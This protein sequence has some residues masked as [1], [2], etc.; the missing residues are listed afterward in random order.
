MSSERLH[1]VDNLNRC[2]DAKPSTRLNS[3]SCGEELE[4]GLRDL[5]G[6]DTPHTNKQN[7]NINKK[8]KG[9]YSPGCFGATVT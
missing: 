4:E 2:G 5:E 7:K 8:P 1:T 6:T 9:V 3:V